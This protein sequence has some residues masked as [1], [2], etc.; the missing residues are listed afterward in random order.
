MS[1]TEARE[2]AMVKFKAA[3]PEYFK[4][5]NSEYYEAHK[6]KRK[7]YRKKIYR[8][9]PEQQR[10]YTRD[11]YKKNRE[12]VLKKQKNSASRKEYHRNY[13][14]ERKKRVIAAYGGKCQCCGET[15]FEFLTI[16]HPEGNGRK[17]RAE[18]GSLY[19]WLEKNGFPQEGYRCLCINCNFSHGMHGYC[20]HDRER[21]FVMR[22]SSTIS[23]PAPQ[24]N[25]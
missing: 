24:N 7:E 8:E 6:E 17:D 16:D 11:Y 12:A 14:L 25:P 2:R 23:P 15:H 5:K 21:E 22:D 3:H 19:A 9:N 13:Y 10:A 1:T 18:K 4:K 20:P